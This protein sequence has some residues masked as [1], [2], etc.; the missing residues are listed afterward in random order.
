LIYTVDRTGKDRVILTFRVRFCVP[1]P[2]FL[3]LQ[4]HIA[5]LGCGSGAGALLLA[6]YYQSPVMAVDTNPIFIGELKVRA[7]QLG[8]EHFIKPI[9]GD[10]SQLDW[11]I[12]SIDLLWSEGAAYHLGLNGP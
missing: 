8:L 2:N 5:D 4:P 3:P 10:M 6:Q 9:Q 7:Q 11:P 1:S 12:G